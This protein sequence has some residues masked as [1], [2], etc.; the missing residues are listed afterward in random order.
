MNANEPPNRMQP[1]PLA[2]KIVAVLFILN[3]IFAAIEML[4]SLTNNRFNINFDVLGIFIGRGLF[5]LSEGW[6]TCALAFLWIGL[7]VYPIIGFMLL[8]YSGPLNFN[9]F[10]QQAGHASNEFTL[11]LVTAFFIYTLWQYHV[12]TREDVRRVFFE[13]G[14]LEQ[15]H[16]R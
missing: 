7:I 4:V 2:L 10:G 13:Q 3:G 5:R 1:L 16:S 12:L 6:R 9:F 14:G 8:N 11:T 15:G